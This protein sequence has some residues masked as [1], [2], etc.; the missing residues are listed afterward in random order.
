MAVA[1]Y[2]F[3]SALQ[4]ASW[5]G[6]P[7]GVTGSTL[8]V[9]RRNVTHEYPYRDEVWVED[10]GRAG[11]RI[12]L[13]GFLLQDAAYLGSP[14]GGDVIAQRAA[15]IRACEQP[16]DSDSADGELVHPSLGRLNVALIEFE[17]EE[18]SERGRYFELRF[19][20]IE[21][22]AQQFPTLAIATQAQTGLSAVAAFAAVAQDFFSTVSAVLSSP[23]VV[24]EIGRTAQNF[25]VEA[26][27]ITQRATSLVAM[28]ATLKGRY[29]RFVGQFTAAVRQPA[30]TIQDLIGAGAQA[31]TAVGVAGKALRSAA[32]VSDWHGM[33][34]ATRTLVGAVQNAN[35]DPHQAVQSLVAL[36]SSINPQKRA[37]AALTVANRLTT[38]LYRRSAVIA[39]AESTTG[40]AL[41]SLEDAES[42]RSTVCDAL[43]MEITTAGDAGNDA[44]FTAL[45]A[46]EV[47][48]VQDVTMRGASL[49]SI[50]T[51]STSE[52]MPLLV[53]AQRLYQ[54]VARY[55]TLLQQAA[56]VHP[57][58]APTVFSA[59]LT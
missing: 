25:V 39:L 3:F 35:P 22:G 53:L 17:C 18:R 38:L 42:L 16:A 40:Y 32:A 23:A 55:D 15:M 43:D 36:Q 4:A 20:F 48:V 14:G 24:G 10:L 33:S 26:Q 47:A 52:P 5:R 9:G 49:A 44:T 8:K 19:S 56:P 45:R 27:A 59:S 30:T 41:A 2:P 51:V 46:L 37:T 29:G 57:A 50:Q 13:S 54:D 11:R 58:F 34:D 12:S 6:V 21:S 28:V 1:E 7:F 31:R